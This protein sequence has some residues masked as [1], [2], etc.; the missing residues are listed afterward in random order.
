[1]E[2]NFNEINVVRHIDDQSPDLACP[3]LGQ[4]GGDD[5]EVP[6]HR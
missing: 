3:N 2:N 4:L 5:F 1:V 6:V